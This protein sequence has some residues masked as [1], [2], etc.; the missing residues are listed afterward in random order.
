MAEEARAW[1]DEA[2]RQPVPVRDL[3]LLYYRTGSPIETTLR[4][5]PDAA[6]ACLRG[7]WKHLVDLNLRVV[8][9]NDPVQ[10]AA[11]LVRENEMVILVRAAATDGRTALAIVYPYLTLEPIIEI[12]D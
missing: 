3:V 8:P 2:A 5:E 10:N 4:G 11:P 6:L 7:G 9:E 12:L 1:F